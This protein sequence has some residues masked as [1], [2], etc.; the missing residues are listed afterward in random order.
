MLLGTA[1]DEGDAD[2]DDPVLQTSDRVGAVV[3]LG[4]PTD[5]R[6]AVWEAPESLPAYKGFPALDLPI[7]EAAE[8]SPLLHVSP[9]DPPTMVIA[10][11]QDKLVPINHCEL[12]QTALQK[13]NVVHDIVI[14]DEAGHGFGKEDFQQAMNRLVGWF[15]KHLNQNEGTSP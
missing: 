2:A 11:A 1:S 9:D 15:E 4:P 10:G 8:H 7:E 6:I 14:F 5:L 13:H 3:A 12:I